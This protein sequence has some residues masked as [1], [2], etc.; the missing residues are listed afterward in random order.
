VR[1]ARFT[2]SLRSDSSVI[3]GL[4]LSR[5]RAKNI[6]GPKIGRVGM[7]NQPYLPFVAC[8]AHLSLLLS[9]EPEVR[10]KGNWTMV[11]GILW[12]MRVNPVES[13][14]MPSTRGLEKTWKNGRSE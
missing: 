5:D 7:T 9:I 14:D 11:L 13:F 12:Y 6:E 2:H 4:P 10:K 8:V 1:A 3:S